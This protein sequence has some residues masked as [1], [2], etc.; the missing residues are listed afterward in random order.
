MKAKSIFLTIILLCLAF[1]SSDAAQRLTILHTNDVHGHLRPCSYPAISSLG[2]G[3][4]IAGS[5][6]GGSMFADLPARRDIGGIA[7]RATL[8]ARIRADLAKQGTPVWLIDAGDI[9]YYSA[10]SNEYHGVADVIAMNRA[11]YDFATLGNH[12]FNNTL[13]QLKKLIAEARFDFL[14][15]NVADSATGRPLTKRY[16]V[17]QIGDTRIGIFGLVTNS[18]ANYPAAEEGVAVEDVFT[19]APDVVAQ[20]RGPEKAEVVILISHCGHS[21]DK[22]LAGKVPGIDVIVGA[23]SH[24]RLPQGEMVWWSDELK[25]DEVNGTVIVQTGEWGVELGRLD[26]LLEKNTAGKWRV[27]RYQAHLIPVT[28]ETPDDPAV[29]A[30]LDSLWAPYAQKYDEVLATATADFASRGDDIS[31]NSYFVDAVRAEFGVEVGFEGTGG[32][33]W[34]IVA[35]PVTRAMLVDLDRHQYTV[36]T[37]RMRGSEIRR[38]VEQS[39][40]VGSGLRYRMFCD[41]L[42]DI[43]VG[44]AP[45]DDARVY[46]CA[47]NSFLAD[48]LDRFEIL[49]KKDTKRLWSDVVMDAMRK[50]RTITPVYDGRRIVVDTLR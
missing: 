41:K 10:F 23:H 47:A 35:G 8:A 21:V 36:V 2:S 17:R 33:H 7:R 29:A 48:R 19:V 24:T 40:P 26:L 14:C 27:N 12:E 28:S 32:V 50:A 13:A 11:G 9:Y 39:R 22:E 45:L 3:S 31:Q 25:P 6:M 37:F 42:E 1:L 49:E 44:G 20:L 5:M 38:F 18:A 30:V 46:S 4:M 43:T 34:P 16:V 15:A